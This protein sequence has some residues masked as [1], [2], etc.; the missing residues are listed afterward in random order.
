MV[1]RRVRFTDAGDYKQYTGKRDT[2]AVAL[3]S[4]V[5]NQFRD[6]WFP[7][8][9]YV[10]YNYEICNDYEAR[11]FLETAKYL[12]L[13]PWQIPTYSLGFLALM[14][15]TTFARYILWQYQRQ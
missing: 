12:P 3:F 14:A 1:Y 9:Y 13:I 5:C 4:D 8:Y 10:Y 2:L 11:S 15:L 6:D 7:L